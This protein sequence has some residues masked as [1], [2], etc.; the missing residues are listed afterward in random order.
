MEL[1]DALC[2]PLAPSIVR[3]A[4]DDLALLRASF[5]H[6]ESLAALAR[7]EYALTL[8]VPLGPLRARYDVRAHVAGRQ[9]DA[10]GGTVRTL[11]FK[12]RADGLGAL[13]GQIRLALAPDGEDATRIEYS[14]WTTATGPLAELPARQIENAL[15]EWVDDFFGEFCA[16]VQAKHGL[17]PNLARG[18]SLRHRHVFLRPAALAGAARRPPAPDL[19]GALTGRAASALHHRESN[20][21]PTWA[22]AAMI[23]VVAALLYAARWFNGG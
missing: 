11:N 19:G 16:V 17:A 15:G 18:T 3:D 14:L 7:G 10:S 5:D 21:V 22:W 12:A 6:C 9:D 8:T 20:P 2:V 13:R 4:L 1:N 23:V